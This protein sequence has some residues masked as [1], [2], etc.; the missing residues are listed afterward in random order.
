MSPNSIRGVPHGTPASESADRAIWERLAAP[1]DER[2]VRT[3]PGPGGTTIQYVT[4]AAMRRRL[5]QVLG[6]DGWDYRIE[7]TEAWLRATLIIRLPDGREVV[8]EA[9]TGYRE[10]D[11]AQTRYKVADSDVFKR[12]CRLLEIGTYLYGAPASNLISPGHV[13]EIPERNPGRPEVYFKSPREFY[14]WAKQGGLLDL[15][16]AYGREHDL[17]PRILRWSPDEVDAAI[18]YAIACSDN[19]AE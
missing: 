9:I 17:S 14:H 1:F 12:V 19:H 2:D 18:A 10:K 16:K 11:D 7:P 4:A 15:V 5:N 6:P 3:R 13:P 8:K